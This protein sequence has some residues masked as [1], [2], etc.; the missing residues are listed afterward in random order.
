M[1]L[2]SCPAYEEAARTIERARHFL[3]GET[4]VKKQGARY[5]PELS[6]QTPDEYRSYK[7]RAS[8]LNATARTHSGLIGQVFRKDAT[9]ELA[10]DD[11]L[12]QDIDL[13][14]NTV[15]DYIRTVVS[16]ALAVGRAGTVIDWSEEE[17]QPYFAFYTREDVLNWHYA[18]IAG[19]TKLDLVVLR[20]PSDQEDRP[21][22]F[23]RE[24]KVL[25]IE[26]PKEKK[27]RIRVLRLVDD[28]GDPGVAYV[29]E[30]YEQELAEIS[31]GSKTK[32]VRWILIESRQPARS[33]QSL[34][35]IPFVF[36]DSENAGHVG[37]RPPLD[38]LISLNLDHYRT[39]ADHKH[40]L[41][42][43]ALPTAWVS[44]VDAKA[45]LKVGS[46][47]AWVLE[48]SKARAGYLE[49]NGTGLG[50]IR[51]E[52]NKI[53]SSMAV[54]G[55]RLLEA[56]KREAETAEAMSIRQSGE[57]SVLAGA[58]KAI[59]ASLTQAMS[60][61]IWWRG[62][63]EDLNGISAAEVT[64]NQDFVS[65][66]MPTK[67]VVELVGAWIQRGISR[68]TLHFNLEQGERLPPEMTMEDEVAAIA[69]DATRD[70][71]MGPEL[72]AEEEGPQ[73]D[74]NDDEQDQL[75]Q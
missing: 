73:E 2:D 10:E 25:E 71:M 68:R 63:E 47:S 33:G 5:L 65:A 18:R 7:E 40:G 38:D 37:P 19:K 6:G 49:F 30:I 36:H 24:G 66:K 52:L 8:F 67:D 15:H 39:S 16:E 11:P 59:S 13:A 55:A 42:F 31:P 34:S 48:D 41:H 35:S 74:Q 64:L 27:A 72:G 9:I 61:A 56:Q 44:G 51:E 12:A 69:D 57:S 45:D 29:S 21:G 60:W 4:E 58:T 46:M 53:E 3:A 62:S 50:A 54:M 20:E 75:G 22:D 28:G 70:S 26:Q 14:G 32:T 1:T 43:S 23:D 17:S